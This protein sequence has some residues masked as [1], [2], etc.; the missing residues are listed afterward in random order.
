MRGLN[1]ASLIGHVGDTPKVHDGG[2]TGK[3]VNFSLATTETFIDKQGVRQIVTEWHKICAFGKVADICSQ[4]VKKGMQLYVEG[5]LKT[6]RYA[7]DGVEK[8]A[9]KI[10]AS[11]VKMLGSK[12]KSPAIDDNAGN[13]L[14]YPEINY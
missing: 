1:R 8:S 10:I 6:E 5:K 3:V 9:T 2:Y 13:Y 7:K 14:D 12:E 11:E 4:Y